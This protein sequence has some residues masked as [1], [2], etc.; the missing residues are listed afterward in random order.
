MDATLLLW[1]SIQREA[2][3]MH[4]ASF[5]NKMHNCG[6]QRTAQFGIWMKAWNQICVD[7]AHVRS[8]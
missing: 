2:Q 5:K 4:Y 3:N 1:N 6:L 7:G 8:D